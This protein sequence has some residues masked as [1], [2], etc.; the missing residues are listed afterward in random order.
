MEYYLTATQLFVALGTA[1]KHLVLSYKRIQSLSGLSVRVYELLDMLK[2]RQALED[3]KEMKEICFKNP[4]KAGGPPKV[5]TIANR[6]L[7]LV[8]VL[9]GDEICFE[10]VDIFSPTGQLLCRGLNFKV[11]KNTNVLVSGRNGSGTRHLNT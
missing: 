2:K 1:C 3:E 11:A 9:Q 4:N 8:K 5:S 7:K 10:D 6:E